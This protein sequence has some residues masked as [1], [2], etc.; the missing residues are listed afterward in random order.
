MKSLYRDFEPSSCK[1]RKK[2]NDWLDE[3]SKIELKRIRN[4]VEQITPN[5]DAYVI[6]PHFSIEVQH[7][8][9]GEHPTILSADE[10]CVFEKMSDQ[11]CVADLV[12]NISDLDKLPERVRLIKEHKLAISEALEKKKECNKKKRLKKLRSYHG[13]R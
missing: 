9:F 4:E 6:L 13:K 10:G 3:E 12:N 11:C 7:N 2:K 5:E 1:S 8:C